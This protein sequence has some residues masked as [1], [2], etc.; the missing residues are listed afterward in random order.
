MPKYIFSLIC[1]LFLFSCDN[2][3]DTDSL[4]ESD[5][6]G[7]WLSY[8][9]YYKFSDVTV[10]NSDGTGKAYYNYDMGVVWQEFNWSLSGNTMTQSNN[11]NSYDAT[12]EKINNNQ[13]RWTSSNSGTTSSRDIFRRGSVRH[14]FEIAQPLTVNTDKELSL[15]D[16]EIVCF[17][18]TVASGSDNSI[19]WDDKDGSGNYTSGVR[20]SAYSTADNDYFGEEISGYNFPQSITALTDTLYIVVD[21]AM[22]GGTCKLRVSSIP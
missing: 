13:L 12:I 10:L 19:T 17:A 7:E 11:G 22:N 5:I 1:L 14:I 20:V 15:N 21:A 16:R 2:G 9:F 8:D 6:V 4:R 3:Q 18:I